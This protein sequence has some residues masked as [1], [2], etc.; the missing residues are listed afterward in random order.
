M[1]ALPCLATNNYGSVTEET[2]RYVEKSTQ[3]S[4]PDFFQY[5]LDN[6]KRLLDNAYHADASL[7]YAPWS[8]RHCVPILISPPTPVPRRTVSGRW[9]RSPLRTQTYQTNLPRSPTLLP[10]C[11]S[12]RGSL[13][14]FRLSVCRIQPLVAAV[15]FSRN[16]RVF[17]YDIRYVA[18]HR[19]IRSL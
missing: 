18:C 5:S 12:W 2:P 17:P 11:A 9:C 14:K 3:S 16:L 13:G 10:H 7:E 6:D 1:H 4:R 19:I 15:V 8:C